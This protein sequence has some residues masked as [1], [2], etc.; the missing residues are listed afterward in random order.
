MQVSLFLNQLGDARQT[1]DFLD[2]LMHLKNLCKI[3]SNKDE[4]QKAG[5]PPKKKTKKKTK[6]LKAGQT[7][8]YE[9]FTLWTQRLVQYTRKIGFW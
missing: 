3:F 9:E 7:V 8:N 1:H 6:K 5:E 2:K 4:D